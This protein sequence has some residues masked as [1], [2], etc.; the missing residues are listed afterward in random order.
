MPTR[1]LALF[2]LLVFASGAEADTNADEEVLRAARLPVDGPSLLRVFRQRTPDEETLAHIKA[3]IVQLGDDE[4]QLREEAS[5]ELASLGVVAS[6][7]LRQASRH[8][9]LEI[10]RRARDTLAHIQEN[11]LSVEVLQSALRV[12]GQSKPIG[13]IEVLLNYAPH[14]AGDEVAEEVCLA[15]ASVAVRDG[16][17]EPLL[18]RALTDKLAVKRGA[19]GVA[20]CRAGC[21]DQ[22]A[23]VRR[24]LRDA[25]VH[26]RRRVALALLEARDKAAVPVLI[27]LLTELP[28]IEAQHVEGMLLQLAGESSPQG[29]LDEDAER[30]KYR[31]AW[32]DWWRR[33][34]DSLDLAKI[35]LVPRWRGYTLAVSLSAL[36]A[37]PRIRG[38]CILE[39]D[40][41]GHIRWQM[42]CSSNPV[43]ARVLDEQRVLVT[44]YS[45]GQVTERNHNGEILR[46][47]NVPDFPLEAR[48]LPNGRT[49]ITTRSRVFEVDRNDKEA[50]T[51]TGNRGDMIVAACPLRGGNIGICHRGGEF[52]RVNRDGKVLAS[53][54]VGRLFRPTGTHIQA[55]PNGHILVPQFYDNKVVEFDGNGREVWSAPYPRPSSAQRLPNGRTLVASYNGNLIEELNKAGHV[56]KSQR[57]DGRLMNVRGR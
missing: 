42:D 21:R 33:H 44:E 32:S 43:D 38:G 13:L 17:A 14:A 2:T 46:R 55:L 40:G 36:R 22:R 3:L 16:E 37:R 4:F 7:L 1:Y 23:A 56:V 52:I 26:V 54:R 12:L 50:W 11:D 45:P 29:G 57:C 48:R 10:R 31:A 15:L 34:G 6:G 18:V 30:R 9:D 24:L 49:L 20:L 39:L 51:T 35:E 8:A 28:R 53:F 5:E 27:E 41:R 19:A 47:I 25:D